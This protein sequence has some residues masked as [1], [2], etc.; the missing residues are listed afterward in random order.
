MVGELGTSK[1]VGINLKVI[2]FLKL[3]NEYKSHCTDKEKKYKEAEKIHLKMKGIREEEC[4]RWKI[5]L[6][7]IHYKE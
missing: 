7:H 4:E 1:L 3:L 5:N 2:E 6:R